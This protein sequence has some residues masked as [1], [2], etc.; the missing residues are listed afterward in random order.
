VL[1][2]VAPNGFA[3]L[4]R[5]QAWSS[6]LWSA[7][8]I[9]GHLGTAD[10]AREIYDL[11]APCSGKLVYPGLHV[12]DS[13]ASTLGVLAATFGDVELADRHFA[14]AEALEL[15][16]DAPNLLARTRARRRGVLRLDV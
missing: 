11:L 10:V 12:F 7:A 1:E 4:P 8:M 16:I 9:A 6:V 3:H 15:Q 2:R 5:H 13:M 14:E